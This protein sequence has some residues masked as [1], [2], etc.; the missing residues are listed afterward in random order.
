[1]LFVSVKFKSICFLGLWNYF[2]SILISPNFKH[3]F[4]FSKIKFIWLVFLVWSVIIHF[5]TVSIA[6]ISFFDL[7][8][9]YFF[10]FLIDVCTYFVTFIFALLCFLNN[11]QQPFLYS[12]YFFAFCKFSLLFSWCFI[13]KN[14]MSW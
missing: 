3:I 11:T 8:S 9:V 7:L 14:L 2:L 1:M 5:Y 12:N 13:L 10:H 6:D 4:V